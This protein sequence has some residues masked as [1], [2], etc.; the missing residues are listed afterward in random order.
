[1]RSDLERDYTEAR[2]KLNERFGH[3]AI[4]S[5]EFESKLS[6]WPKIGSNDAKRMQEFSDY[7][8]QVE[9]ATEHISNLKIFEYSSKL[10][11]LVEK[12]PGWFCSKWSNKVQKLQQTEGQNAFPA[13]SVF[14]REVTCHA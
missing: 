8:Q 1:M 5:T 12:L 3:S 4:L 7:L 11:S 6:N 13:L 14:V 9:L 2:K 10:Q